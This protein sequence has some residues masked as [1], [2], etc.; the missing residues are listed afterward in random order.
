MTRVRDAA[1][2]PPIVSEPTHNHAICT[3]ARAGKIG[4]LARAVRGGRFRLWPARV[5]IKVDKG[6]GSA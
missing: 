5:A 6:A 2:V 1:G 3:S 4:K